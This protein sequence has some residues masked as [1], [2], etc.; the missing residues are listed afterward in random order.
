MPVVRLLAR[1]AVATAATL[2][3]AAGTAAAQKPTKPSPIDRSANPMTPPFFNGAGERGGASFRGPAQHGGDDGHL[4]PVRKNME[5]VSKFEPTSQGPIQPEQIADVAIFKT[6]AYLNS[7]AQPDCDKGGTYVVDIANLTAPRELTFIPALPGNYHGEGAHVVTIDTPAFKGDVLAVNNETCESV[8]RG[9]GFDLYDVSNP[10]SPQTL[11]QGFGDFGGEGELTKGAD[12][13]EKAN[14][15]HSIFIWDAGDKAY[16]VI[17]DNEE[18][19]DIDIFD[20]TDPRNPRPVR[21]YDAFDFNDGAAFTDD[22]NGGNAFLHDM[23]VKNINGRQTM[24]V[25]YWDAG[26]ILLNADDPANLTYIAD[27]DFGGTDPLTGF[28]PP[29]GNAH[30]AEFSGDNRYILTGEEDFTPFRLLE[31]DVQGVGKFPATEVGGGG[32]PNSLPDAVLNGPMAYGGY[33]C[34]DSNDNAGDTPAPVPDAETLFPR[35]SLEDGEERILV[36]QR[37]PVNDTN[38]DYDGD[39]NIADSDD[40]CFPGNKAGKARDAGWDAVLI[41]NHHAGGASAFCGSG[42][43]TQFVVTACT[44][45]TAGHRIFDDPPETTSPYND[46]EEMAAIGE[47][48][49]YKLSATGEFDGWGYMSMYGTTPD[50]NGK[51]PLL[52]TYAVPEA[53]NPAYASGFG[54]LSI[55]E[56]AADPTAPLSYAA[57]YSAGMRV[58]SFEAGKITPQ[59]AF[60]DEGGNNF[61]GVEQFTAPNCERLIAG[62]DRDYGLYILRYTGPLAVTGPC[63]AGPPPPAG[64]KPGRCT[65]LLAVTAGARLTGTEAGDQITGTEVADVVNA[66]AGDDCVDGIGGN[67]DLRGGPGVDTIDGQRGNDRIR[68]DSGRG[69]LRG[70]T[71]NDRLSGGSARDVLT[72]NTG[73]DRLS[74]G[75]GSDQLF[76]SSGADR[77]TGGRGKDVIEGG[78]GNDRIFAKDGKVDRIDCGFGRDTVVSRDRK[79]KLTSCERKARVKK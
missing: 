56:Q 57:Y 75:R 44:T 41:I 27:S 40:A 62:S 69:N 18:L 73:R 49:P 76:G 12:D 52:D 34:P 77:I 43:Y 54:D 8:E 39:G 59:G 48:S 31:V 53:L 7:W 33:A 21:E 37:G 68:G 17:V 42:G 23:V 60:I 28:N 6:Q 55:H 61:W 47:K 2:L 64:L 38:E 25:D 29:E 63:P 16:A 66:A 14:E 26:Y 19:H 51:L 9:G 74:G 67:D 4:P 35:A 78:T 50:E 3:L 15:A 46:T 1:G 36:V 10:A 22:A 45:H 13:D 30:Q 11:V 79:D 32:S 58:F 70:G 65:N 71:G 5:L 24:M 20:I 72:G